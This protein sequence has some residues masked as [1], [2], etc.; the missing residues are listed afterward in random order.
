MDTEKE[1]SIIKKS[2]ND[3]GLKLKENLK[4]LEKTKESLQ[5]FRTKY[6]RYFGAGM[7]CKVKEKNYVY[8][9]A[10]AT[11][12]SHFISFSIYLFRWETATCK[13]SQ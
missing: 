13:Q 7:L 6:S 2:Q 8:V 4:D 10:T 12:I 5:T 11:V 1:I 9:N 3:L